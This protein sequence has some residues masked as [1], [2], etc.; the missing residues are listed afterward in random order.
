MRRFFKTHFSQNLF[1]FEIVVFTLILLEEKFDLL[2]LKTM[3]QQAT[4][5][6]SQA[7]WKHLRRHPSSRFLSKTFMACC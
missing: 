2:S 4:L 6:K 5:L 7:V 3:G 1:Y